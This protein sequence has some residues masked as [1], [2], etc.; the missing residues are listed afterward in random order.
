MSDIRIQEAH[1]TN[2]EFM[3]KA[4]PIAPLKIIALKSCEPLAKKT[5]ILSLF[6]RNLFMIFWILR[7]FLLTKLTRI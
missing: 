4:L 5:I 1:M 2:I 3:E 6:V 7:F